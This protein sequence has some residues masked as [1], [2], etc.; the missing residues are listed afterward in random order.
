V[1]RERAE[2]ERYVKE[3]EGTTE[4]RVTIEPWDW[5]Y[6]SEKVRQRNYDL[7]ESEVKPYFPLDRMVE[8]IFD[9]ARE[10]FGLQFKLRPDLQSYHPDVQTYE[11]R[12]G[13]GEGE[14][15]AIFLHD[16]YARPHKKSGAWM[17]EYRV[18]ARN[19]TAQG[20]HVVP[21]IVNNNNFNKPAAGETAL[22]SFDDAR[23]LFHEFGHGL[24][25]MLSNVTYRR[26]AGT[27]V[28]RDFVELPSQLYEH[29][30]SEPE[31]LKRHA[32]HYKT[33]AEMPQELLQRMMKA[34][35]FGQGFATIEYSSCV[36]VD[37]ALHQLASA[38]EVE[39]LDVTQFENEV[40]GRMGMP[41][42]IVMRH[43]PAHFARTFH[44]MLFCYLPY[45]LL[46]RCIL[47]A[48]CCVLRAACCVLRAAC[49]V[50]CLSMILLLRLFKFCKVNT[51]LRILLLFRPVCGQWVCV[52]LL[53]VLVG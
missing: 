32:R 19:Y 47:C 39:K 20:E 7:D 53:R 30:L 12:Q 1:A 25:G 40:L 31:V 11:V 2:L 14:L 51:M 35:K 5:R 13:E 43:R 41:E 37:V 33:G 17:S 6:Y 16:N 52:S 36:L 10:L 3:T 9:C 28:L 42:G 26:L 8:A 38:A 23:T 4:E 34:N 46:F 50:L 24:H 18:Q 44:F 22:L 21:I 29:W 27:S 48:V 45:L 49:C 15:V